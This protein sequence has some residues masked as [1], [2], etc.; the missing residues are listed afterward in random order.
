M[1]I[2]LGCHCKLMWF[3]VSCN[4]F[5]VSTRFILLTPQKKNIINPTLQKWK[6]NTEPINSLKGL[7]RVF[8]S[9]PKKIHRICLGGLVLSHRWSAN[10]RGLSKGTE[11]LCFFMS[12]DQGPPGIGWVT[13]G[14]YKLP[15]FLLTNYFNKPWNKDS[16]LPTRLIS[17][18]L[19]TKNWNI[20]RERPWGRFLLSSR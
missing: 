12:S 1:W 10:G 15:Q 13:K 14:D 16:D 18:L 20:L 2:L 8:F 6:K 19:I 3:H 5:H 17:N 7:S 9:S 11:L 4:Q